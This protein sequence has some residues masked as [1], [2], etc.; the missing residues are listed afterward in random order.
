M[1]IDIDDSDNINWVTKD[2]VPPVRD[3]TYSG[4]DSC[5]SDYA[6]AAIASIESSYMQKSEEIISL[7]E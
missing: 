4:W 7:S 5:A 2:I 3:Q 6:I 1:K